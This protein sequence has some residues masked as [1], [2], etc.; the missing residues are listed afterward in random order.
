MI[1]LNVSIIF[2]LSKWDLNGGCEWAVANGRGERERTTL[3]ET[4]EQ[5]RA[6]VN[7]APMFVNLHPQSKGMRYCGW[8]ISWIY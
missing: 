4:T 3:S 7:D 6:T 5:A 2:W 1:A 8:Q